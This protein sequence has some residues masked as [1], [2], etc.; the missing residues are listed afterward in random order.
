MEVT[1]TN[2]L[3]STF[4]IAESKKDWAKATKNV[5]FSKTSIKEVMTVFKAGPVRITGKLN[6]KEKKSTSFKDTKRRCT[7]LK[8]L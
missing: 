1:I 4:G 7:T 3:G 5:K 2:H 8:E 6:L